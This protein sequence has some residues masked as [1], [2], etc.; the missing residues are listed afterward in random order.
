MTMS[1][2]ATPVIDVILGQVYNRR[3]FRFAFNPLPVSNSRQI[4]MVFS[5]WAIVPAYKSSARIFRIPAK[6]SFLQI[7]NIFT[8]FCRFGTVF[9]GEQ[10]FSHFIFDISSKEIP[11]N[12]IIIMPLYKEIYLASGS[13]KQKK[14]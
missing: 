5:T 10:N 8:W 7:S 12:N 6:T 9:H 3:V 4:N 14:G 13:R 1:Q 2:F 11:V